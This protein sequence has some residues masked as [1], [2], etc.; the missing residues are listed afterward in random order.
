MHTA[1]VRAKGIYLGSQQRRRAAQAPS[2]CAH[3]Q[4]SRRV[5]R[6]PCCCHT[7]CSRPACRF[8]QELRPYP[9]R[10]AISKPV[11]VFKAGRLQSMAEGHLGTRGSLA[12]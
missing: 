12:W 8:T 11:I 3:T 7:L 2:L 10:Q 9:C 5:A 4:G 1:V 6:P